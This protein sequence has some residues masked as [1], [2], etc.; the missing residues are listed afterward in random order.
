MHEQS[1]PPVAPNPVRIVTRQWGPTHANARSARMFSHSPKERRP[2]AV[3]NASAPSIATRVPACTA[4]RRFHLKTKDPQ[5]PPQI[6]PPCLRPNPF[7][8]LTPVPS[9]GAVML[10]R[11]QVLES[12]VL[13]LHAS[14]QLLLLALALLHLSAVA[15][16]LVALPPHFS[17]HQL[18][19]NAAMQLQ[20]L[21]PQ[22]Q[23]LAVIG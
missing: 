9:L 23:L 22:T 12:F 8:L 6:K 10:S 17:A 3:H 13:L 1:P 11:D 4:A 21:L 16:Q 19:W 7:P 5:V 15:I 18:K 14:R 2:S 20:L